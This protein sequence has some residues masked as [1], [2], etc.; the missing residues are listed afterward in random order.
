M[1]IG[2]TVQAGLMRI[3]PS[4]ILRAGEAQARVG[5]RMG[6]T[7]SGL[8]GTYVDTKRR[9]QELEGERKGISESLK[10]L[11][12]VQPEMRD[13]YEAQ[14]EM[15]ND[16]EIPLSTRVAAG[17]RSL[18][19]VGMAEKFRSARFA[20]QLAIQNQ[21]LQQEQALTKSVLDNLNISDK[22]FELARKKALAK[23]ITP[24]MEAR[25]KVAEIQKKETEASQVVQPV[26]DASGRPMAGLARRGT[27][28]L[29]QDPRTGQVS[30]L[31]TG[32]ENVVDVDETPIATPTIKMVDP[33]RGFR[34][35]APAQIE[36][37]IQSAARYVGYGTID[38]LPFFKGSGK[39]KLTASQ[40]ITT[41]GQTLKPLL[42]S[43]FGGKMTDTQLRNIEASIPL[44]SDD[45]EEGM[46]KMAET[47]NLLRNQLNKANDAIGTLNP[48]TQAFAEAMSTKK[49]IE[50]NLPIIEEIVKRY[51]GNI[52]T[53]G[54][55]TMG[56]SPSVD[57]L[58]ESLP[59]DT[60]RSRV[61]LDVTDILSQ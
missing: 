32:V 54:I 27:T 30:I 6:Q 41:I 45:P 14:S 33:E 31:G 12:K 13:V 49:G 39:E 52:P 26:F 15:L 25:E 20:E 24:E 7:V 55:G 17:I 21:R 53:E 48:K 2:D 43:E 5:E 37:A 44:V 38:E 34:G 58:L 46:A 19:N 42:M 8:I 16:T 51:Y 10:M 18:Q 57:A 29:R 60:N 59:R 56:Q 23:L 28:L 9:R 4:A 47:V 1:A 61:D 3:D 11:A 22:E 35:T 40:R 36:D 50:A